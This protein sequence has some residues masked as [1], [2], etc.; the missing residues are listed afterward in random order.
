MLL[1]ESNLNQ[2]FSNEQRGKVNPKE[3]F[4]F[5]I[6]EAITDSQVGVVVIHNEENRLHSME[7]T[8]DKKM[9]TICFPRNA[10][11]LAEILEIYGKETNND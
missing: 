1:K 7:L 6:R 10:D 2:K 9:E 11:E 4:S 8:V 3:L 5:L